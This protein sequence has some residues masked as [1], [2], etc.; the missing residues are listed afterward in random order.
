MSR[1]TSRDCNPSN[2]LD[3]KHPPRLL[4]QQLADLINL[5]EF[6][7][8][9]LA[10]DRRQIVIGL[11]DALSADNDRGHSWLSQN[12]ASAPNPLDAR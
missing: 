11:I 4:A 5:L 2:V 1:S 12:R 8:S 10:I 3:P 7:R 9:Q 6:F